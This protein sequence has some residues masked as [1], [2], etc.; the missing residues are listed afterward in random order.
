MDTLIENPNLQNDSTTDTEELQLLFQEGQILTLV[1]GCLLVSVLF[2]ALCHLQGRINARLD[3]GLRLFWEMMM[4]GEIVSVGLCVIFLGFHY[5]IDAQT[6]DTNINNTICA[7][8]ILPFSRS[9]GIAYI[10]LMIWIIFMVSVLRATAAITWLHQLRSVEQL[11]DMARGIGILMGTLLYL[12]PVALLSQYSTSMMNSD[13]KLY[14][15]VCLP[16]WLFLVSPQ[17]ESFVIIAG[18]IVGVVVAC[19]SGIHGRSPQKKN[20][21]AMSIG[22]V[23]HFFPTYLFCLWANDVSRMLGM[24]LSLILIYCV[25]VA[26]NSISNFS[27]YKLLPLASPPDYDV[28]ISSDNSIIGLAGKSDKGMRND[29]SMKHLTADPEKAFLKSGQVNADKGTFVV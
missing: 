7:Q 25:V 26:L 5:Y 10:W 18:Y 11:K 15:S 19:L 8:V 3:N 4:F 12:F 22:I 9:V 2:Y 24:P 16:V 20:F 17:T 21:L 23:T 28:D 29:D 13:L 6:E 1:S 27:C 14:S